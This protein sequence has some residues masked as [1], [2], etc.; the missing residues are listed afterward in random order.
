MPEAAHAGA[1]D[2][3]PGAASF[4]DALERA[5]R[6]LVHVSMHAVNRLDTVSSRHL[7]ALQALED[8]G[9]AHVSRLAQALDVQPST[10]SRLSD[11]LSEAGLVTR[12]M[13]PSNRRATLVELTPQGHQVLAAVARVRAEAYRAVSERMDPDDRQAL[14]RGAA[15][16]AAAAHDEDGN[17]HTGHP[18]P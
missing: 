3:E 10:A 2:A 8:L 4:D 17:L 14:L 6:E 13:S 5:T 11:R 16:F 1:T 12:E 9:G 15:A 18:E 7:Q